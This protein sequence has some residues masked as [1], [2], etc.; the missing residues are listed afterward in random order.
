MSVDLKEM[1]VLF[2][3]AL[4][5]GIIF[6]YVIELFGIVIKK[7]NLLT[8]SIAILF[9]LPVFELPIAGF[10]RGATGDLS[11]M[12][13]LL[14]GSAF[15]IPGKPVPRLYPAGIILVALFFYPCALG[16]GMIDPYAWGYGSLIFFIALM[17]IGFCMWLAKWNRVLV[18]FSLAILAWCVSWHESRN[19]WDYLLD[20]FLVV[21]CVL[22]SF[23]RK[24]IKGI[25]HASRSE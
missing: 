2:E 17:I 24:R 25:L 21:G 23:P 15:F 8:L 19:L 11:V 20:P 5:T 12:T 10:I 16:W 6:I 4:A 13:L 22:M 9:C 3:I 14:L 1:V 7:R 18:I